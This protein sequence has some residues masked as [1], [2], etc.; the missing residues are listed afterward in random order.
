MLRLYSASQVVLGFLE[1]YDDVD[2]SKSLMQHLH[3]REFEAPMAGA[4]YL[5]NYSDELAEHYEPDREVVTFRNRYE[6]LEKVEYYL[7]HPAEADRVRQAGRARALR[8][9]TWERRF[10]SLFRELGLA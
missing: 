9:H 7:A 5:T 6:L 10:A 3:L 1:V 8:D 4:L 2:T